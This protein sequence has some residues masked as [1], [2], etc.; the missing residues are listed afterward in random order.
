MVNKKT[1]VLTGTIKIRDC[2]T[3]EELYTRKEAADFLGVKI[4]TMNA[5]ASR[6]TYSIPSFKIRG[7]VYYSKKDLIEVKVK[8][9]INMETCKFK[10]YNSKK[11]IFHERAL[12]KKQKAI[13]QGARTRFTE[14]L[15]GGKCDEPLQVS[16]DEEYDASTPIRTSFRSTGKRKNNRPPVI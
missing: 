1:K 11:G 7:Y 6:G 10:K 4:T 9:K 12:N 16:T 3:D 15:K 5:W 14:N 8:V 2:R 13:E